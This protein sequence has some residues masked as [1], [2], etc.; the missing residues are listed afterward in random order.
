[1]I[2]NKKNHNLNQPK[3]IAH[4]SVPYYR[5][6][7]SAYYID[8]AQWLILILLDVTAQTISYERNLGLNDKEACHQNSVLQYLFTLKFA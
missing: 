6:K 8:I 1:M 2:F 3:L 5:S 4:F 7:N